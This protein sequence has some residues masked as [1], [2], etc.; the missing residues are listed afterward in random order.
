[1]RQRSIFRVEQGPKRP[2]VYYSAQVVNGT[3]TGNATNIS[4]PAALF[5]E[6]RV[7]AILENASDYKV[8]VTRVEINGPGRNLPLFIMPIIPGQTNIN[9]TQ[10]SVTLLATW[11]GIPSPVSPPNYDVPP[12]CKATLYAK[13]AEGSLIATADWAIESGAAA[14]LAAFCTQLQTDIQNPLHVPAVFNDVTITPAPFNDK[15]VFATGAAF[16]LGIGFPDTSE[17]TNAALLLGLPQD[18]ITWSTS[19]AT[20]TSS[21]TTLNGVCIAARGTIVTKAYTVLQ[22]VMWVPESTESPT[23]PV[24]PQ[25]SQDLDT[26]PTY[27]ASF[28]YEHIATVLNAAFA[29]AYATLTTK[30]QVDVPSATWRFS[31]PEISWNGSV[32]VLA[33]DKWATGSLNTAPQSSGAIWPSAAETL[34]I[35]CNE[36]LGDLMM[37][38]Q[39]FNP[40]GTGFDRTYTFDNCTTGGMLSDEATAWMLSESFRSTD[41]LWSPVAQIVITSDLPARAEDI[42]GPQQV[43]LTGFGT[44]QNSSS[45]TQPILT[46]IQVVGA[47]SDYRGFIAFTPAYL[48]YIDLLSSR[49]IRTLTLALYW[50]RALDDSLQPLLVPPRGW[51]AIK[52]QF[53]PKDEVN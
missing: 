23:L 38:P 10:L 6:A 28:S 3:G 35:G 7:S 49:E 34:Q 46:D 13:D 27:Y 42:S 43:S 1:M 40:P 16:Q 39:H 30:L 5:S 8:A 53:L 32:F 2:R 48:R 14:N 17:G 31:A 44:L 12:N 18:T 47:A 25:V 24:S 41:C 51:A 15:I 9:L 26:N 29:A 45:N 50:R 20:A 52:L 36:C 22:Q 37:F 11:T 4:D 19:P 21:F 33:A